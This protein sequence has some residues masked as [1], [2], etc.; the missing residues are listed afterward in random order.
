MEDQITTTP[1]DDAGA[2]T[3]ED[4]SQAGED[5]QESLQEQ[6]SKALDEPEEQSKED[7]NGEPTKPEEPKKEPKDNTEKCPDKFKN[8][9]G[10]VNVDNLLKSYKALEPLVNEKSGWEKERAELLKAKEQLDNINK[11]AEARAKNAGYESAIDMQQ[12]YEVAYEEAN[13]YAQYLQ[14]VDDHE[15]VRQKLISYANN[16]TPELM[17]EIELEF[18]PEINKRVAVVSD[19]LKQSFQA[20]SQQDANTMRM[21]KME[22]VVKQA[23]EENSEIFNYEPFKELFVNTL[24]KYGDNFTIEDARVLIGAMT[25][26]KEAFRAEFEKQMGVKAENN[27]ATDALAALNGSSSAPGAKPV[28]NAD[29]DNMSEKELRS[30]IRKLI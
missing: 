30:E 29:I 12:V 4:N 1:A 8:E 14:Y 26:M 27:A 15:D 9:D 24:D 5:N 17:E 21:M 20:Q 11:E 22:N 28:T 16:P 7:G 3:V 6:I 19:R 13:E 18:A 10:S 23:V 2:T 25:K